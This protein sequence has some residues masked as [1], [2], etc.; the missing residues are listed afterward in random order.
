[1]FQG[2]VLLRAWG[3]E[4]LLRHNPRGNFRIALFL[5]P[6]IGERIFALTTAKAN[7]ETPPADRQAFAGAVRKGDAA[8]IKWRFRR[9][10]FRSILAAGMNMAKAFIS[11][12]IRAKT[13]HGVHSPF[14]YD[15]IERVFKPDHARRRDGIEALRKSLK[16]DRMPL[17][18]ED[19]GAGSRRGATARTVSS[20]ARHSSTPP[21]RARMMQRLI[22]HLECGNVLELGTNLGLTTAYLSSARHCRRCVSI[23]ADKALAQRA[24]N[25]LK[26]LDIDAEVV[27]GVFDD[28]LPEV[29]GGLGFVDF[30]YI[31]GNHRLD[32]TLTY[33]RMIGKHAG[34]RSVIVVGD[35]H[36]SAGM[37]TAWK[38]IKKDPAVTLTIDLFDLGLVFFHTDRAKQHFTL[39][40]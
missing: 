40:Y 18:I 26:N 32:P 3:F 30:A 31:D 5:F 36:W 37:E 14:V 7:T 23:E 9:K 29:L 10:A 35:I 16:S 27:C 8:S 4:S 2:H 19:H 15:L 17:N 11:H 6:P 13:R 12:R 38:E 33:F 1:M 34:P 21:R 22:D 39:R 24:R 20:V 28:A 25:H